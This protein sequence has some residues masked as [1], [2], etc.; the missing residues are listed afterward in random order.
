MAKIL[1][2]NNLYKIYN[3]NNIFYINGYSRQN[4]GSSKNEFN[5]YS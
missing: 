4:S 1:F 5:R 2:A 3:K